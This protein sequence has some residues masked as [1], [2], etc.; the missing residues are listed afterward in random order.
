[1]AVDIKPSEVTTPVRGR[2]FASV[3]L[4]T[5]LLVVGAVWLLDAIDLVDIRPGVVLPAALAVVGLALVIGSFDGPHSGLVTFGVFLTVA[6]VLSAVAPFDAFRGGVG[7]RN[8]RV[9]TQADLE[10]DYRVGVGDLEIDLSDLRMTDSATVRGSVGAG[11]LRV[12][13]PSDVAVSIDA[14]SGAGKVDLLG[15]ET[16][17]LSVSRTYESPGFDDAEVQ[18]RLVLDVGTG[19]IEVDR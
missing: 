14:S 1:M 5:I 18:L 10:T 16:D 15:Q 9:Q 12:I 8:Y 3:V 11:T 7:E 4:G 2:P 19:E 13:L 17:G 6:V